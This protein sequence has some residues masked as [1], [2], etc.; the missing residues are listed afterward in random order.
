M[1]NLHYTESIAFGLL[2]LGLSAG[3]AAQDRPQFVW[4]GQ[5]DGTAI[6]H[7]AGKRLAVQI[8][9]GAPVEAPE[10]SF[11]RCTASNSAAVRVEVL[12]G[13]GYVHVIDQPSIENQLHPG[14]VD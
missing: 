2:L 11:F 5:V 4:Q 10:I 12:E 6:L 9:D 1:R 8:Q 14:G 13:R 3:L 7:L